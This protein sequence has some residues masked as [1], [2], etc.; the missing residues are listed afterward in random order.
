MRNLFRV[1]KIEIL[2][3][4]MI[5]NKFSPAKEITQKKFGKSNCKGVQ[6]ESIPHY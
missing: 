5:W 2:N 4:I 3:L 6:Y 1:N